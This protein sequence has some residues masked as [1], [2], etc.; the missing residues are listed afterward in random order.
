MDDG[1]SNAGCQTII[2]RARAAPNRGL[3]MIP[4]PA[5]AKPHVPS[6]DPAWLARRIEAPVPVTYPVIDSHIHLW[7]FSDPP[8]FGNAYRADAEAAGIRSAVYVE[9]TM[10]IRRD[11]PEA[12]RVLGEIDFAREQA[13]DCSTGAFRL[14]D[15][16]VGAADLRLGADIRP[17]LQR[18]VEISC[19]RFRGI[20]ARVA[21]DPDPALS[22]GAGGPPPGVLLRPESR[23]ALAVLCELGLSLDVYLFH[24][25]LEDVVALAQALP[26]LPIILNHM[27]T[28]LGIGRYGERA[29][30]VQARWRQGLEAVA[31]CQNVVVKIGGF[32]I[33]RIAI[34]T[35]EAG[36]EPP[37][38]V[39][40]AA[41]FAPWFWPCVNA[42]GAQRCLYG[43]NFPVDKTAMS[44]TVQVNAMK[45][46]VADLP[47]ADAAAI[48]GG[49]AARL[50]R[51]PDL[52]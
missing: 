46:L 47:P 24:T 39:D 18:A 15:A 32:A 13:E 19:G 30:E 29:E 10:G 51:L 6:I 38:S 16:I 3:V 37:S 25:Q 45:R 48:M 11:G 41:R 42:F 9:S 22:Y 20:R 31:A 4:T 43:S 26:D 34:V 23:E 2:P 49:N 14:A 52:A 5:E 1:G 33:S 36:A 44:L 27:G 35:R 12:E 17:I 40:L 21:Y 7:D 8:Y 50:Y 28:P